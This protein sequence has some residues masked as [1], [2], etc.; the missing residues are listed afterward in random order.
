MKALAA[1]PRYPALYQINTRA[2]LHDLGTRLGQ[3]PAIDTIPDASLDRIA[4]DGFDWLWP[5]G[6]WQTGEAGRQVS[7]HQ[8]EW[9]REYRELLPDFTPAD[10]VGSPF[11]IREYVV[12]RD[13]GGPPALAQLRGKLRERGVRLMLDFVPNHTALDHPWVHDH[14]EYYVHGNE[15]DLAREPHNYRRVDT[16]HGPRVL[17]HGRDPYF[18]GWPDTLQVNYR[19]RGFREAMLAVLDS[20]AAQCDGVRCDMAMLVLP[21]V[22]ARTWG[23]RARPADGSPPVD[24]PFW[25]EAIQR[26][27]VRHPG[28]VFMAEAYWDLE[29]T[30]QQ[31]GFDYTYDKRLY[32]RLHA[33]DARA[34]RSHLRADPDFQR[35]SV[36]F[37]E[38]HDEPRAASA[39]PSQVHSAAAAIAFLVPGLRFIYEGQRAGRRART[40][41]HLGRRVLEP[42]DRDRE[43]FY[44]RMFACMRRPEVREGTWRLLEPHPTWAGNPTWE[45]FVTFSWE[46]AEA[47]LLVAV[48]YGPTP[49][50]CFVGLAFDGLSGRAWILR[51]LLN[52]TIKYE[53]DGDELARR[54]LYLDM[55]PWGRH[56]FEVTPRG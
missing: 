15:E 49:G 27:R 54:G 8:A 32:D 33:Q 42:V 56:V 16:R 40:S 51:D 10:V 19:H 41:N 5:L 2:W 18:P 24:E 1:L 31:Q 13:L 36:R 39:F 50:Q 53:R 3:P 11:A 29:W 28:F 47:R 48:N 17:A 34:V 52:P 38:N 37:L 4:N 9:Q 55:P 30:L 45:H 43:S 25:V 20:V 35:K 46:H 14:P 6:V 22:I 23:D 7:L 26:T 12:H 44:N 21:E